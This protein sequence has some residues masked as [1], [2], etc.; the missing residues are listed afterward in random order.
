M[1]RLLPGEEPHPPHRHVMSDEVLVILS[2]RGEFRIGD[3]VPFEAGPTSVVFAPS[4]LPHQ[5]RAVSPEPLVWVTFVSPNSRDDR[6]E[7]VAFADSP[8]QTEPSLG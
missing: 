7:I 3:G 4:G 8:A 6:E 1:W 2:G 5:L